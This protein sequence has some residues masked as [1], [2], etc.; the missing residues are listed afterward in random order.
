MPNTISL[1]DATLADLP[2]LLAL[3]AMFVSDRLSARQ[4]RWHLRNANARLRVATAAG[5]LL[6][7]SLVLF[8]RGARLARLYSLAI[9]PALRGRGVGRRLLADAERGARAR[10]CERLRLEV[11]ADNAAAIA[12]YQAAGYRRIAHVPAYY[13]DGAAGD[14]YEKLLSAGG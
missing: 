9:T 14:R 1:R 13:E 3:E 2:A 5:V 6:G 8:R 4:Y 12:L 10:G 11:R 7:S